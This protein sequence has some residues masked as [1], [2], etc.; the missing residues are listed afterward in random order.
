MGLSVV[1]RASACRS[2]LVALTLIASSLWGADAASAVPVS[3]REV[4]LKTYA[5]TP[6]ILGVKIAYPSARGTSAARVRV[7]VKERGKWRRARR[8]PVLR[9]KRTKTGRVAFHQPTK[10]FGFRYFLADRSG[11]K[12]SRPVVIRLS[13]L[14]LCPGVRDLDAYLS[15]QRDIDVAPPIPTP[16]DPGASSS[17]PPVCS[18]VDQLLARWGQSG[19]CDLDLSGSVDAGDLGIL[20]SR[21]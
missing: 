10:K 17:S 19:V 16:T 18:S 7:E 1:S 15:D 14:P 9:S 11:R 20:L 6:C 5:G 21:E 13:G 8:D 4:R 2:I 12:L 3:A